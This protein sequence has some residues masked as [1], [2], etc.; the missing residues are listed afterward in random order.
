VT[1]REI[2]Q[3]VLTF[4]HPPRI[5]LALPEPYP[6]DLFWAGR[7]VP[8]YQDKELAPR[9][10]EKRR[11]L[12]EWGNTWATLTDYD[13]GEV[14]AGALADWAQLDSYLPPDFG[15]KED[16]A[17]ATAAFAGE[18][19]K[20]RVAWFPG[21]VFNVARYIRKLENYLCD[22]IEYPRQVARLNGLVRQTLLAGIDRL[23]EAGADALMFPEDWGTQDRLMISPA[24]WRAVFKPEFMALAGRA[25]A[26]GL[27]VFMHSCGKI[28]DIIPDL[29]ECGIDV[30]QFDQPRLHG[31]DALAAFNGRVTFWCPVDI[32]KTLQ[33]RDAGLI[34]AEAAELVAKLGAHGGGFIAGHY[35]GHQAIGLTSDVQDH[36]CRAFVECGA[37]PKQ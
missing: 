16:Y 15:R 29:I 7:V 27:A 21:F 18:R 28:T 2:I 32:Q 37:Y 30:L 23:A 14:V 13:K 11:W 10:G 19:E 6:N 35:G 4:Q 33:T 5:G 8:G 26:R 12:D 1:S 20:Y 24:M 17:Q 25:R 31:I 3:A 22:L 36:A 34:A 9:G